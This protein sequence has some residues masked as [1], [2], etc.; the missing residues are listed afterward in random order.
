[1]DALDF[2]LHESR[3]SIFSHLPFSSLPL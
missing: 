3:F 2:A 1:M